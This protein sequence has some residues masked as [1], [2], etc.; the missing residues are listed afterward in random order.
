MSS[1]PQQNPDRAQEY[2]Q[3]AVADKQSGPRN[4]AP[5]GAARTMPPELSTA[6]DPFVPGRSPQVDE[7]GP[8]AAVAGQDRPDSSEPRTVI[9]TVTGSG[10]GGFFT[11]GK[12]Q[13]SGLSAPRAVRRRMRKR[14]DHR[15]SGG[16]H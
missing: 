11:P 2:Y 5:P 3:Q 13:I 9:R 6:V 8:D 15:C 16:Q 4:R 7:A 14:H 10:L 1:D 12:E